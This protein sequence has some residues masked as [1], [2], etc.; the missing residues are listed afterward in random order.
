V[1]ERTAHISLISSFITS[2]FLGKIAPVEISDASGMNLMNV[3]TCKYDEKL[4]DVCSG[5]KGK[6]DE[7]RAKLGGEPVMGGTNMG[8]VS[9]WWVDRFGFNSGMSCAFVFDPS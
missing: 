2:L 7:L 5:G 3:H 4:L 1:Y 6:G 9:S 8:K